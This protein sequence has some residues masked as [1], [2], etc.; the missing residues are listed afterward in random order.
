MSQGRG[1][2]PPVV[3]IQGGQPF[4]IGQGYAPYPPA[5]MNT[6]GSGQQREF[7]VIGDEPE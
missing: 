5:V 2:Y 7:T 3:V 6:L 4:Q 1:S